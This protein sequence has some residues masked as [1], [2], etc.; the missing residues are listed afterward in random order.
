MH[1]QLDIKKW[2]NGLGVRVPK[3]IAEQVNFTENQ[4][5]DLVVENGCLIV[6]PLG[7][8]TLTLEERLKKFNNNQQQEVM[9]VDEL[10][11]AEKW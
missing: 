1:T 10:L 7:E 2:G 11:G 3:T 4:K 9:Q 5:V 6:A 8:K